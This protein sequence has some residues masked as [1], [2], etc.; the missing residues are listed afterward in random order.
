MAPAVIRID[1]ERAFTIASFDSVMGSFNYK[2][3]E[4]I[5]PPPG[6]LFTV[7]AGHPVA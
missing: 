1:F 6:I 4:L 7:H 3:S 2:S 5:M